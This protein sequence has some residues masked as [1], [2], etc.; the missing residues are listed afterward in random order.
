MSWLALY[1]H[2][3]LHYTLSQAQKQ[4]LHTYIEVLGSILGYSQEPSAMFLHQRLRH[5]VVPAG[6]L[7]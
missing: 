3:A 5:Q 4:L 6:Q 7:Q 2:A 1:I